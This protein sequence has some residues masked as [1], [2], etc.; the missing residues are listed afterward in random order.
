[1][2][3]SSFNS[4]TGM[5]TLILLI[6][7]TLT[8]TTARPLVREVRTDRE[9]QRLLKVRVSCSS[10]APTLTI[11]KQCR[12]HCLPKTHT[13][14]HSFCPFFFFLTFLS[15]LFQLPPTNNNSTTKLKRVCPSS[16][17]TIPMAA[18]PA[19]KS[20]PILKNSPNNT[21]EKLSLPRSMSTPIVR[22]L[23]NNKFVPCPR[24]KRISWAKR[25]HNFQGRMSTN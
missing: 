16:S 9:F 5:A 10:Q 3:A 11:Q 15:F 12:L 7:S 6:I 22:L 1:M 4:R 17:T 13:Q 24:F 23:G 8:L 20:H 21:K 2:P 25:S 14:K 18:V 19:V